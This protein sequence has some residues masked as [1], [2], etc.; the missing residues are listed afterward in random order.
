MQK[1]QYSQV[2]YYMTIS[3]CIWAGYFFECYGHT[4]EIYETHS[5]NRTE[6]DSSQCYSSTNIYGIMLIRVECMFLSN[7]TYFI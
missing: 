4:Y 3:N 5:Q 7:T 2:L 6:P 1:G